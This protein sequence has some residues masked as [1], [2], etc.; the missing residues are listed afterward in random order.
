MCNG[1]ETF[2]LGTLRS[3]FRGIVDS[4]AALPGG[5]LNFDNPPLQCDRHG[6]SPIVRRQLGKD[7]CDVAFDRFFRDRK[8]YSNLLIRI[9]CCN[10]PKNI[11]FPRR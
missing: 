3:Y 9:P 7:A 10:Q 6:M 5:N 1:I 8:L 11:E 2:G 4:G